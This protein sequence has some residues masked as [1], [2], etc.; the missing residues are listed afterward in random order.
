MENEESQ[1]TSDTNLELFKKALGRTG[2]KL[3]QDQ[4]QNLYSCANNLIDSILDEQE[5]KIFGKTI[6][7]MTNQY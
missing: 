7:Q 1:A 5:V 3:T 6:D 2:K 4:L